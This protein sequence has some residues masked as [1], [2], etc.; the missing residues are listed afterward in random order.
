MLCTTQN[1]NNVKVS[2]T[3]LDNSRFSLIA[4]IIR[5]VLLII[6]DLQRCTEPVKMIKIAEIISPM[7]VY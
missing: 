3:I 4:K 6:L 5:A 2:N 7:L 1:N